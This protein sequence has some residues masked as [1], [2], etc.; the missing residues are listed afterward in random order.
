MNATANMHTPHFLHG[1]PKKVNKSHLLS[2]KDF[3][4]KRNDTIMLRK[5]FKIMTKE[6]M[7]EYHNNCKIS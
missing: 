2:P 3:E 7:A 1:D 4:K 6:H 5:I